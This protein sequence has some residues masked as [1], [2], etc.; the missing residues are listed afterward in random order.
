MDI[1]IA[2]EFLLNNPDAKAMNKRQTASSF[3]TYSKL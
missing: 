2:T 1:P 3:S